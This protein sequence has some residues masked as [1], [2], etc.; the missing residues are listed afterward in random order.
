MLTDEYQSNFSGVDVLYVMYNTTK[1]FYDYDHDHDYEIVNVVQKYSSTG[2]QL[3]PYTLSRHLS[4]KSAPFFY[5]LTL[6]TFLL[7]FPLPGGA[8]AFSAATAFI[9]A[10]T[11]ST[12]TPLGSAGEYALT[13]LASCGRGEGGCGSR[14]C[15]PR[16]RVVL[17]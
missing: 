10:L 14:L 6:T 5:P 4:N 11:V 15:G 7:P 12:N 2:Y 9:P 8:L 17:F 13:M 3:A 16:L 1:R